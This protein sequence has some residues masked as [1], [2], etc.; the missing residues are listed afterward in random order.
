MAFHLIH[1]AG[2]GNL[3]KVQKWIDHGVHIDACN[4]RK[5]TALFVCSMHGHVKCMEFLM[6]KGAD[7]NR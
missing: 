1:Y 5:E 6:S 7:P 3:K 4:I 2:E